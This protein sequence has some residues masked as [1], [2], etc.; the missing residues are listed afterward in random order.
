MK[1]ETDKIFQK[2]RKLIVKEFDNTQKYCIYLVHEVVPL[3][4]GITSK[5]DIRY[6]SHMRNFG[7]LGYNNIEISFLEFTNDKKREEY[8]INEI[9]NM[10]YDLHNKT[11]NKRVNNL[12][13]S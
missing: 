3:Y 7:K 13:K 5:F 6:K 2:W 9:S 4:V 11:L 10:G 1:K 12:P 8:F